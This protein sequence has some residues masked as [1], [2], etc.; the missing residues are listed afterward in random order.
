[1]AQSKMEFTEEGKRGQPPGSSLCSRVCLPSALAP[2][3]SRSLRISAR[4][5]SPLLALLA[6]PLA[7]PRV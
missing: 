7:Q 6:R 2:L 4:F 1:M 5:F 3:L